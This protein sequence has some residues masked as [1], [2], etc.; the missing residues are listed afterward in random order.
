MIILEANIQKILIN[1]LLFFVR[2]YLFFVIEKKYEQVSILFN[3]LKPAQMPAL[4]YT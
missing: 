1:T 3:A 4:T 2:S